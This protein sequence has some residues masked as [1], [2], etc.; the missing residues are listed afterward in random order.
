LAGEATRKDS[1]TSSKRS[2]IE[3][4]DIVEGL[5]FREVMGED[6]PTERVAL[7]VEDVLPPHPPSGEVEPSDA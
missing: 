3:G 5:G 1:Y 4:F 7:D 2:C 6:F